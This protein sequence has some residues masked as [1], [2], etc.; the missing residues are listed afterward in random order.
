MPFSLSVYNLSNVCLCICLRQLE[1]FQT[2]RDGAGTGRCARTGGR[3]GVYS[4]AMPASV[5]QGRRSGVPA[6]L[7][8]DPPEGCRPQVPAMQLS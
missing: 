5:A 7:R 2:S 6:S 1:T 3:P 8:P 4:G